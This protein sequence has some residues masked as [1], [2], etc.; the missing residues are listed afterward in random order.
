VYDIEII[1]KPLYIGCPVTHCCTFRISF[2]TLSQVNPSSRR[3][4]D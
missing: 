3:G 1:T 4:S 2:R